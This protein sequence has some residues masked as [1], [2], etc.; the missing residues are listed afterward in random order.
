MDP[1]N[2]IT[3]GPLPLSQAPVEPLRRISRERDRPA[4][5]DTR[6]RRREPPPPEQEHDDG[7]DGER[8]RIDVRV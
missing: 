5:D 8:P 3:P 7:D 4:R 6:R 1:I 2:P